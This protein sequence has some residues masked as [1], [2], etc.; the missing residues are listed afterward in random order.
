MKLLEKLIQARRSIRRFTDRKVEIEKVTAIL[1]SA[2]WAPS[3][4]NSQCWQF[5]II[6]DE[7]RKEELSNALSKKNPATLTVKNAPL[8]IAVCAKSNT[9]GFYNGRQ[10][11]WFKD[12]F[13]FDLGLATQN[14]CLMAHELGLG[15]VIV[16][17]FDHKA[18]GKLLEIP[19]E[20]EIAAL[21][22]IGYP[23]HEPSAPKR[24]ELDE[25]VHYERF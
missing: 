21:L 25:F 18:V 16:G 7:E 8:V 2:R 19:D 3:W 24:K 11:T 13:M 14:M 5:I 20:F 17:A 10:V 22:P 6:E 9:S 15:S 23:D 12:W 4:G 1:E